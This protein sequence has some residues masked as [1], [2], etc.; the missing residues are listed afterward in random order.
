MGGGWRIIHN[1][2]NSAVLRDR[3]SP[4]WEAIATVYFFTGLKWLLLLGGDE[5]E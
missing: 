4:I 1:S 5:S 3:M 2:G